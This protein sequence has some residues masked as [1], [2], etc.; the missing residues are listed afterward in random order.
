[1]QNNV[2]KL[3]RAAK[4]IIT[5]LLMVNSA[6]AQQYS[7]V[8]G[9]ESFG[10]ECYRAAQVANST[11]SA[12]G[13]DL[14][15]CD[16]AIADGSL[17]RESLIAS[18]VNRGVVHM[19]MGN[20]KMALAD[21]NLALKMDSDTGEAY[22]NRGNLWFMG[23]RLHNAI[24]DY[25]LAIKLGVEKPHV[26]YLNRGMAQEQLGE[27]EQARDNYRASLNHLKGWHEAES[28]LARVE[29]KIKKKQNE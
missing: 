10:A 21:L 27:L 3:T 9:G 1:M 20:P 17:K 11:G 25:D 8:I 2:E 26:A 29:E 28:R 16:R 7:A 18:Y 15:L 4:V 22:V 5:L 6:D 24:A 12:N 14:K 19:A 23:Q 13:H